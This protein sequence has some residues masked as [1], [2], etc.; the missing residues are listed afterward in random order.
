[1][2]EGVFAFAGF[3]F[4][5]LPALILVFFGKMQTVNSKDVLLLNDATSEQFMK[6]LS[7]EPEI[8]KRL[9]DYRTFKRGFE[10]T[11]SLLDLPLFSPAERESLLT[12]CKSDPKFQLL[13]ETGDARQFSKEFKIALPL[14]RRFASFRDSFLARALSS[15]RQSGAIRPQLQNALTANS[16]AQKSLLASATL[17]DSSL[18]RPLLKRFVMRTAAR[19][20]SHFWIAVGI[21]AL[22]MMLLPAL[23]R[24]KEGGD[25]WLIPATLLLCGLGVVV[26]FSIK[27]PLRDRA[28]YEHHLW[29]MLPALFALVV[30]AKLRA[31]ARARIQRYLYLWV[32]SSILLAGA[33]FL[34]G[35]GPEGVKLNLFRFQPVE[36]IK[37]FL[38]FFLAGYLADR[39]DLIADLSSP[40]LVRNSKPQFLISSFLKKLFTLP[41]K[42]DMGPILVMFGIA[43]MLFLIIKDMGPGL[44]IFSAFIVTFCLTTGRGSFLL[45]GILLL[46]VGGI[47]GY[48]LHLG[49][50]ATRVDMWL[51]PFSNSHPNGIQLAQ[52]FW[53]AASGGWTGSG[54][55]L[56]M[57]GLIPRSG[58]DLAFASW[59]EETGLAGSLLVLLLFSLLVWRGIS[60]G[61]RAQTA[62][63]RSLAFSLTT[64]FGLQ[65]LL[66]IAGVTGAFPLSGISLPFL[67]YGNS[68][69]IANCLIIGLLQGISRNNRESEASPLL[70][71]KIV[72]AAKTFA[73]AYAGILIVG[74][75]GFR[76]LPLLTWQADAIALH[77]VSTPDA[78]GIRRPHTNP[79]LL[80]ME[81]QIERGS[82]YDSG[83]RP[84]ATSRYEEMI[85]SGRDA[86]TS[87][88][89]AESHGRLYPFGGALAH[90]VGY[91]DQGVGGPSGLERTY[92]EELRGWTEEKELL[93][94]YRERYR[95]FFQ[96]R[97]GSDITL[98][99]DAPLQSKIQQILL[100]VT[101]NLK[102]K[103]T[104]KIK[105]RSAFVLCNPETG[106]ILAAVTTPTYDPNTLTPQKMREYSG[107]EGSE[108]AHILV[109]RALSGLYPPG[110]TLKV[111][112]TATALET[113]PEALSLAFDCNRISD[114]LKW[115][116]NGTRY[117]HRPIRDD[118][119]DPSFGSLKLTKA[120]TVSSNIYFANLA[121]KLDSTGFHDLLAQ[122]LGFS[123]VPLQPKFDSDLPDIGFGQGRMLATPLEMCRLSA[124][125]ANLGTAMK[126]RLVREIQ[127][128]GREGDLEHGTSGKPTTKSKPPEILSI[129]FSPKTA[130][131]LQGFM[132]SVVTS[133]TA[134]GVFDSLPFAVAGKT[135]TA[136][137]RQADGEPHSWFIGFA[138]YS[139]ASPTKPKYAFACVVENG[140]YGKR[141]AAVVCKEVLEGLK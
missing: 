65:T 89:L 45:V 19:A 42:Q 111:A 125:V 49:V 116:A 24:G 4:I 67:S 124:T 105:D 17:L 33:L 56:G 58:S 83:G 11:D 41:R 27:D 106:D 36:V 9:T 12:Q 72:T 18:A 30:G 79:R 34:F 20:T 74:I 127:K 141:V 115:R 25:P 64:L 46:L 139:E 97:A 75:G 50:F 63:D 61:V 70:R 129:A 122:K 140:G 28:V 133:G 32:I 108:E 60:I 62:F 103:R 131:T 80:M 68:A 135:G 77:T 6:T 26:L 109:N 119:G 31:S 134:R 130:T 136:Q 128:R 1:M 29:G 37:L 78:D 52:S 95:P 40:G 126:P 13:L 81:R 112:T 137:N 71:P 14:S 87:A 2:T 86:A 15:A 107:G 91:L 21:I 55:G 100:R 16:K 85:H 76:L 43:L 98:T 94:D 101:S 113:L 22:T 48:F 138:P 38:V 120:F 53:G 82:L 123:R 84:V 57:P 73:L 39:A 90:L 118:E 132:R 114:T 54:L 96:K 104:D 10:A 93:E 23:L 121:T 92:Q 51:H 3:A 117:T 69:L 59:V 102:D 35:S 5:L 44:V 47:L 110:S 88:K 7:I 8:A 66:I 99:I